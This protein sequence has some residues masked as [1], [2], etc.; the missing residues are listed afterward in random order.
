[1]KNET[2]KKLVK[3][4]L[5]GSLT[6]AFGISAGFAGAQIQKSE[7]HDAIKKYEQ[8][9]DAKSKE[10]DDLIDSKNSITTENEA[11]QNQNNSLSSENE[12]LQSEKET[13]QQEKDSLASENL[14]L[15]NTNHDL[16]EQIAD[17]SDRVERLKRINDYYY[18]VIDSNSYYYLATIYSERIAEL[19]T[20]IEE[21]EKSLEASKNDNKILESNLKYVKSQLAQIEQEN[22]E[23]REA[24]EEKL[25]L[26][27]PVG[28]IKVGID[29]IRDYIDSKEVHGPEDKV[30]VHGEID[31]TYSYI[32]K[33]HEQELIT[34]KEFYSLQKYV[35][36]LED[37]FVYKNI[38]N[39]I[40]Y[41][42]DL[43]YFS[44]NME[45]FDSNG[46]TIDSQSMA[47]SKD[48]AW[49]Y[50]TLGGENVYAVI[51]NGLNQAINAEGYYESEFNC[52][53]VREEN[54]N[55][56]LYD[57]EHLLSQTTNSTTY[58]ADTNSYSIG[59]EYNGE[60]FLN[61]NNYNFDENGTLTSCST[62]SKYGQSLITFGTM[63]ESEFNQKFD[64]V[65]NK[66]QEEK[67]KIDASQSEK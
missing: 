19:R 27:S 39:S 53:D 31:S 10:I 13:L 52:E 22:Q 32:E 57:L 12:T 67:A 30:Y 14:S 35:D 21:L 8:T 24:L 11:L 60:E 9:L 44:M 46:Q 61:Y 65:N 56:M 20:E 62:Q 58:N 5:A 7:D 23:L 29:M 63:T 48:Q 15:K 36:T 59:S 4:L 54:M 66:I 6:A 43:P 26:Q 64:E 55:G 33:L 47:F 41:H 3:S 45:S 25:E 38:S 34:D 18:N 40:Q 49:G 51:N 16:N 1:M 2:K 50:G 42:I 17:L 37:S 28:I